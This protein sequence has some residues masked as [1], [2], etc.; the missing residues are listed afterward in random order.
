M[1][2]AAQPPLPEEDQPTEA[3]KEAPQEKG[4]LTNYVIL[5]EHEA[6]S[7]TPPKDGQNTTETKATTKAWAVV[8]AM[9]EARSSKAAV[10]AYL[11]ST[12]KKDGTY[13][14]VPIRSWDPITVKTETTT[15]LVYS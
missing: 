14:A 2:E 5:R 11:D 12:E 1:S 4:A 6:V 3:K 7:L 10:T 9:Q 13:C 8:K 15:R